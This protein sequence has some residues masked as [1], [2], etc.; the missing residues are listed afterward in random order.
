M[1]TI[2]ILS[3]ALLLQGCVYFND[4]GVSGQYYNGCREYYDSM[5]IYHKVCDENIVDYKTV[6]DGIQ[7][8]IDK[9]LDAVHEVIQ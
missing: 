5:G 4:R 9:S 3:T 6:G 2:L 7:K 8:G 1:K